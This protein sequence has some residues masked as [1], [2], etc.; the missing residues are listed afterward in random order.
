VHDQDIEQDTGIYVNH[1]IVVDFTVFEN[2]NM[3]AALGGVEECSPVPLD[4]PGSG[5]D[6]SAGRHMLAPAEALAYTRPNFPRA[7]VVPT[8]T[9]NVLWTQPEDSQ[10]FASFR[11]DVPASASL[12]GP[13]VRQAAAAVRPAKFGVSPGSPPVDIAARTASQSIC[14][15]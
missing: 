3:V 1:F 12:F 8:D 4:A 9:A 10:I 6:L 15:S 2:E 5:L 13:P 11:D 14:V 7:D